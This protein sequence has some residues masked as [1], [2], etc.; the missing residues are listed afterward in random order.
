M[1]ANASP[2]AA[3]KLLTPATSSAPALTAAPST[4]AAS[5]VPSA[6]VTT[7]KPAPPSASPSTAP[8][9]AAPSTRAAIPSQ[10]VAKAPPGDPCRAAAVACVS[11]SRQEAW[12]VRNGRLMRGPIPVA[13]G[14][15]GYG[16]E[17]GTFSVYRKNRMWYS[18]IYNNAPMPYSVF[19]D[20]GEAFHEGS[21]YVRSHGCVHLS[22]NDAAWVYYFLQIGDEVEVVP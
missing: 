9:T 1:Q 17:L 20:G 22:S 7:A 18:T 2:A 15:Y 16:T 19:F 5:P 12:F 4:S 13:T 21:V 11:L 6:A 3:A 8:S 10:T 14:R